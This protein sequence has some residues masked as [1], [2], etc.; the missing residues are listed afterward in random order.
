MT[1]SVLCADDSATMQ[2]VAEITFRASG[3]K[4]VGARSVDEALNR[5]RAMVPVPVALT[6][7]LPGVSMP[8]PPVVTIGGLPWA[9]STLFTVTPVGT[10]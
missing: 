10:M 5:A 1:K 2:Q 7:R 8:L 4:V 6:V 9:M 3:Y